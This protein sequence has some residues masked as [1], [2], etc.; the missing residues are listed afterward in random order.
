MGAYVGWETKMETMIPGAQFTHER[1]LFIMTQQPRTVDIT[2]AGFARDNPDRDKNLERAGKAT[3]KRD[4]VAYQLADLLNEIITDGLGGINYLRDALIE[5]LME[6]G[7]DREEAEE[8]AEEI[9]NRF[10]DLSKQRKDLDEIGRAH[11]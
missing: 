2:P 10:T 7:G 8:Y 6:L 9:V 1:I 5:G 11:V 4:H 3:A